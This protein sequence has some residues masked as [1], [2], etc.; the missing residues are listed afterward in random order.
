MARAAY[1]SRLIQPD[2]VDRAIGPDISASDKL[3]LRKLLP[4]VP[5]SFANEHKLDYR[6]YAVAIIDGKTQH[7]TYN[8]ADLHGGFVR[9]KLRIPE[10]PRPD[11]VG[12]N[13]ERRPDYWAPSHID[14]GSGPYRRLFTN[15]NSNPNVST[16]SDQG[17]YPGDETADVI[18]PCGAAVNNHG[19]IN[20]QP[21]ADQ[22]YAYMG[23]WSQFYTLQGGNVDAGLMSNAGVQPSS[24]DNYTMFIRLSG[25]DPWSFAATTRDGQSVS[26]FKV[27]C[28]VGPVHMEFYIAPASIGYTMVLNVAYFDATRNANYGATIGVYESDPSYGGWWTSCQACV[29]KRMTSIGQDLNGGPGDDLSDGS[30]FSAT[31]QNATVS[32]GFDAALCT[33]AGNESWQLG[34][35]GGCMEFPSW[36]NGY[37][38]CGGG[39][40]IVSVS[41]FNYNGEA[42]RI[43]V[44]TS[45]GSSSPGH[46]TGSTSVAG[47]SYSVDA[48]LTS[49]AVN[50]A[51]SYQNSTSSPISLEMGDSCP[52]H[53]VAAAAVG[54][55]GYQWDDPPLGTRCTQSLWWYTVPANSTVTFSSAQWTISNVKYGDFL[56]TAPYVDMEQYYGNTA[57]STAAAG[58]L[59]APQVTATPERTPPPCLRQPCPQ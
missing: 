34:S 57:L 40:G 18:L 3:V 27:P 26:V 45:N 31:W 42:D 24:L 7:I 12:P 5:A 25:V 17:S 4:S 6:H 58:A 59:P 38:D 43:I 48:S 49:T 32:C 54:S 56:V 55:S 41:N 29:L 51:L 47:L 30:S 35:T 1:A 23:G 8:R 46:W 10:D 44:P 33:P 37:F 53:W 2:E 39:A 19:T 16:P 28:G 15:P 21:F 36:T 20:G 22:A 52:V 9:G 14:E 13:A 11:S 50:F